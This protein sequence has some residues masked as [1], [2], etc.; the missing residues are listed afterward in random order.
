MVSIGDLAEPSSIDFGLAILLFSLM[1]IIS[2]LG[3][4][5]K[6]A[7]VMTTFSLI[8]VVFVLVVTINLSFIWIWIMFFVSALSISIS[9][10]VKYIL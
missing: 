8:I 10:V 3:V 5:L 6:S 4:K 1:F 9:S 7:F 2:Y